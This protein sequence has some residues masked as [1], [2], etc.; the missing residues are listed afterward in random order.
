MQNCRGF[1]C[2]F[3]SLAALEKD[4]ED[5]SKVQLIFCPSNPTVISEERSTHFPNLVPS[6]LHLMEILGRSQQMIGYFSHFHCYYSFVYYFALLWAF[7]WKHGSGQAK[8]CCSNNQSPNFM[9][10][11][12][13]KFIFHSYLANIDCRG[14]IIVG[15][16]RFCLITCLHYYCSKEKKCGELHTGF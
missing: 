5:G 16:W 6:P 14:N 1:P 13:D 8:C 10:F 15:W 4:D 2:I 3:F 11:I 12:Q 7:K 9:S